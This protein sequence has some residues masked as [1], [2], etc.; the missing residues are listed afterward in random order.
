MIYQNDARLNEKIRRFGCNFRSLLAIA[1]VYTG[2]QLLAK[3]IEDA[4]AE[5]VGKAMDAECTMNAQL[6]AVPRWA[7]KRLGHAGYGVAQVG[8][9]Y[10][11]MRFEFWKS[12]RV[13]T[14]LKGV[15]YPIGY[16]GRSSV[17]FH[18]RLGDRTGKL[19]FDPYNPS[20][21]M[22]AEDCVL[23]YQVIE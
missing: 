14:I 20:P 10:P 13:F 21:A 18:F 4:Y 1:E 5:L 23:L 2:K 8:I 7:F 16:Q 11:P 17:T 15:M 6:S 9:V 12:A 19:L 22:V 3:D